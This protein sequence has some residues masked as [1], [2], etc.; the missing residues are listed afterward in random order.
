VMATNV[1]L[2]DRFSIAHAGVGVAAGSAGMG[3]VP[4]LVYHSIFEV[5]ENYVLKEKF[6]FIFPDS[7]VDSKLNI[8]GDTIAVVLGWSTNLKDRVKDDPYIGN[9]TLTDLREGLRFG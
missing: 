3:L 5:L 7:S 8:L 9:W 4:L 2:F 1:N 6:P